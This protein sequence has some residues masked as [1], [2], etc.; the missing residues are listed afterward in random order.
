MS[1][2]ATLPG[3][4]LDGEGEQAQRGPVIRRHLE[5]RG[6]VQG[7]GFRPFVHRLADR[8]GLGGWVRNRSGSVEIEI[9][10]PPGPVEGF[11]QGLQAEAPPL[12]RIDVMLV[13]ERVPTGE[14]RFEIRPS[15]PDAG[16]LQPVPPDTAMCADCRRELLDGSDRRYRYP[17]IN[18][19]ACGPRFTIIEALPYDRATT[20]M[21]SFRMCEACAREYHDP[22][23]RRYHA[24]PNACG[25]CGPRVWLEVPGS[26]VDARG[27]GLDGGDRSD[28][29]LAA[30]V[31]L[32]REGRIVAVKG[33][34]GFHLAC[35]ARRDDAVRRLRSRKRRAAKPFA[36]MFP[37]LDAVRAVCALGDHEAE[38]L[39]SPRRP[40][41]LLPYRGEGLAP[42]VA[43]GLREVGAMLPSTPLHELLLRDFGG[44]L[45]MTS[46]NLAEEPIVADDG[47]ARARLGTLA[48]AFLMHDRAIASRYDDSVIRVFGGRE[49]L[50][51]RARG[52]AP[53]PLGV[54]FEAR[55]PVLACGAHLK[56]TFCLL[57]GQRAYLSQHLGDLENLE[58]LSHFRETL[59]LYQRL[60]AVRPEVIAHDMHPDYLSTRV[61]MEIVERGGAV[62]RVPVQ[63]H[64]AHVVSCL[65][66]HGVRGPALGVAYDGLGYGTDGR[67]WGGEVLLAH[68]RGFARRAHLREA[69]MPGGAGAVRKPYRMA[70][71]YLYGW[72]ASD[73]EL[74]APFLERLDQVE[75]ALL[76]GRVERG[77]AT[78]LTSSCGRLFDAVSA[79]LGVCQVARYEGQAAMELQARADPS[80]DGSYPF[81]LAERGGMWEIDPSALLWAVGR[82]LRSGAS[83]GAI[84]MRFHRA[85]AEFTA[86]VCGRLAAESGIRQVALSGG[87]FQNTLLLGEVIRRLERAGLEPLYHQRVPTNDGG[88]SFGQAVIAHSIIG[89][90]T[91]A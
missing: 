16:A 59:A 43:P 73:L 30:A 44:P 32:L 10:G 26:G 68:W 57:A 88:I 87:V 85:V 52:Y 36:V 46:G 78:A 84:A 75:C 29:M 4:P 66:E 86:E 12:A 67:L 27:P 51:R 47:E 22:A 83:V 42:S 48:D 8:H 13:A 74:F 31:A 91:D 34:G 56:S 1:I 65:V 9:E 23:D 17:F 64:H 41:V 76:R 20:T 25:A 71:G 40:I 55:R 28:A 21:R 7:V 14:S 18:C 61:A 81:E 77:H 24:E 11:L 62:Q 89:E 3:Q 2:D 39:M 63:H 37:D 69:P 82:D 50:V 35:D 19:T 6:T 80:A 79:L 60:F 5:V 15:L 45:V 33:M 70:L 38:L 53:E 90:G 54:P 58:T 72:L 49:A